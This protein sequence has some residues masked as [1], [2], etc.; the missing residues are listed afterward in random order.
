M[1]QVLENLELQ[2]QGYYESTLREIKILDWINGMEQ[3]RVFLSG[4]LEAYQQVSLLIKVLK[5]IVKD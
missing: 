5:N 3:R 1:R 4:K 2:L